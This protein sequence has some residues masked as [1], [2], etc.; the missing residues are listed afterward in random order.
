MLGLTKNFFLRNSRFE[1]HKKSLGLMI[2]RA[3]IR[4]VPC[5]EYHK[6]QKSIGTM[7]FRVYYSIRLHLSM[8]VRTTINYL[9]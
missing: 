8:H 1:M 7:D 9:V 5:D 2:Y 3:L 4:Y 6:R